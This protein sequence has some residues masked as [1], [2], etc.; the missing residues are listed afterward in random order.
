MWDSVEIR[1]LGQYLRQSVSCL[2]ASK[3]ALTREQL[4]Q[5]HAPGPDISALIDALALGLLR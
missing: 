5:H 2:I 1:L 3:E 4:I